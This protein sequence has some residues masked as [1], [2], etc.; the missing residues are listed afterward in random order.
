MIMGASGQGAAL[1]LA[2]A[3]VG[4]PT[5]GGLVGAVQ[6]PSAAEVEEARA[7]LEQFR[8][9]SDIGEA[10]RGD[11]AALLARDTPQ[12]EVS[13][14]EREGRDRY[15]VASH[16]DTVIGLD[17]LVVDLIRCDLGEHILPPLTLYARV[18]AELLR[19]DDRAVLH[20]A[21][22]EYWG[23]SFPFAVWGAASAERF[24]LGLARAQRSLAE[25]LVQS[26]F[27]AKTPTEMT[28]PRCLNQYWKGKWQW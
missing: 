10:L 23:E 14:L 16:V 6:N 2:M 15:S 12:Y 8:G 1:A 18:D 13:V 28:W 20:R 19:A 5:I 11:L 4:C 22:L 3:I 21:R 26:F 27:V 25:Q 7:A 9:E 17:N 24:A